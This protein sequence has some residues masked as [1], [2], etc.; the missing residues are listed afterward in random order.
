VDVRGQRLRKRSDDA[1]AFASS[2][3]SDVHIARHVVSVNMAH[4]V[5][6]LESGEVQRDV[7]SRCLAFLIRAAGMP[8]QGIAEDYHQL[9]EQRAVD[10]LGVDIAG[11]LNYGKSRNDQVATAIRM[12]MR[13]RTLDLI[14]SL[15]SIEK[16]ILSLAER[17][18]RSPFPGYTHLQ[19][20][21]PVTVGHHMLAHFDSFQRTVERLFQLYRRVNLSPMGSAA[22]GGTSVKVDRRRVASLLGF[23]GIVQ[24][25][26]D[27]VSSRDLVVEA[28][29]TCTIAMLELSRLAE[30]VILWSSTEFG[31]LEIPD[32]Y[33]ASSSIMP[34]KKNAVVAEI[35]RA[36]CGSVL[37]CLVSASAI[38]K[39]LPCSYNLDLQEAT[40][41]LWSGFTDTE[42]SVRQM[43]GL[44]SGSTF[45]TALILE[46]MKGDYSTATALANYLV[47]EKGVPFRLAHSVVGELVRL[48]VEREEPFEQTVFSHIG[49][50][51]SRMGRHISL[52]MQSVKNVL[53][54]DSFL[55][56]ITTEGGSNPAF[57]QAQ[58]RLRKRDVLSNE[59]RLFRLRSSLSQAEKHLAGLA[60]GI[61]KEVRN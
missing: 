39:S 34:Q 15:T 33:S 42:S 38:L 28:L 49:S 13:S 27:G 36:K 21:Q 24:N 1:T 26:M 31:F 55:S 20:A 19:R 25:A 48:S 3:A 59:R 22:L 14:D 12:E 47:K 52:D 60:S 53:E 16:S 61:A 7:A 35:A 44:L 29:A 5:S 8:V 2:M 23:D 57:L 45:N 6:L 11:Y 37:G 40:P 46:S 4:M 56:S 18:G 50:V 17:Y 30:E 10:E 41:G 32:E 54:I 9:L 51:S 43:A 58:L